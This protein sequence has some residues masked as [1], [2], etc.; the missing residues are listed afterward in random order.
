[1][2]VWKDII[3]YE[4]LYQISNLGNLRSVD[5]VVAG[6]NNTTRR[7]KGCIIKPFCFKGYSCVKLSKNNKTKHFKLH[8]LVILCFN[9]VDD[10]QNFDVNHLD[11]NKQNNLLTNLEW[12]SRLENIVHAVKIGLNSQSISI[13]AFKNENVYSSESIASLARILFKLENPK[14]K[15]KTFINNVQRA[16]LTQGEYYGYVF[17]K[18]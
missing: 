8:R 12:C 15:E 10:Y 16:V 14:C 18:R 5:R 6:K 7:V 1:M 2:E 11:G 9:Y 4:G 13:E 3:N 17:K